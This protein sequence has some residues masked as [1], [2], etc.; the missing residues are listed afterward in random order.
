MNINRVKKA[1]PKMQNA[2]KT[3]NLR[4]ILSP[5]RRV[6]SQRNRA[7]INVD[8]S[9]MFGRG[10]ALSSLTR[11]QKTYGEAQASTLPNTIQTASSE[12][13]KFTLQSDDHEHIQRLINYVQAHDLRYI[14][15]ELAAFFDVMALKNDLSM[16]RT[17]CPDTLIE[18]CIHNLDH[19]ADQQSD[20]E[21]LLS[22]NPPDVL[23][24]QLENIQR[25][26]SSSTYQHALQFLKIFKQ[27]RPDL[28][29]KVSLKIGQGEI[30]AQIIVL[31]N[32]LSD[33]LIDLVN[34]G[35]Y[36]KN[37]DSS[38]SVHRIVTVKEFE[39]YQSHGTL[40]GFKNI[41]SAPAVHAD[42]FAERQYRGESIPKLS[43]RQ[44]IESAL[45]I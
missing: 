35:Q 32:D 31:L 13:I 4:K 15:L 29:T 18:L 28:S 25:W 10:K 24:Y 14:I 23:H 40:L 19:I 27:S 6:L 16:I 37:T 41:W 34:I 26:H 20:F 21:E 3:D 33:H 39:R 12:N 5:N 45:R 36:T 7:D 38:V 8:A 42:Y 11:H 30:E 17:H 22:Q 43:T 2:K 44:E 9:N 1:F